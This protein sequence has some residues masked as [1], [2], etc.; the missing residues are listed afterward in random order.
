M[1][2]KQTIL[3]LLAVLLLFFLCGM[4]FLGD[5]GLSELRFLKESHRKLTEDNESVVRKSLSFYREIKRLEG[6]IDY[7]EN[8]ARQELGFISKD[9]FIFKIG[10]S[11]G[12]TP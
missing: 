12:K 11:G 4:I 8:V 10:E 3:M 1:E 2:A 7:I 6:D 5:N 9:E